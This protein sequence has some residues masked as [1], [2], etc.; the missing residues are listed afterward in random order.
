MILPLTRI[1]FRAFQKS[2]IVI[3]HRTKANSF[4]RADVQPTAE[5]HCESSLGSFVGNVNSSGRA[6][7]RARIDEAEERM[8]KRGETCMVAPLYFR[9]THEVGCTRIDFEILSAR[10]ADCANATAEIP[11]PRL[12]IIEVHRKITFNADVPVKVSDD[13]RFKSR[14][15]ASLIVKEG[16]DFLVVYD[17]RFFF[18]KVAARRVADKVFNFRL[19][20]LRQE[21]EGVLNLY[22]LL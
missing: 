12:S 5:S 1:Y 14:R 16:R 21:M 17:N 10:R 9:P 15:A 13:G 8:S 2:R 19:H 18:V 20:P 11:A 7:L 4:R 22:L 6:E 3:H